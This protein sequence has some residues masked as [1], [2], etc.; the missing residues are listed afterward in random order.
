MADY[1]V[2]M[3]DMGFG[4]GLQ[5]SSENLRMTG[6]RNV[7]ESGRRHSFHNGMAGLAWLDGFL[8]RQPKRVIHNV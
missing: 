4:F 2:G 6:F 8:V 7:D 5:L 3:A 1:V